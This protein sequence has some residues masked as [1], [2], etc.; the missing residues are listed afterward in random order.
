MTAE[1]A[2][3]ILDPETSR[4]ALR[5]YEEYEDRLEVVNE[6]CRVAC[7]ALC[8]QQDSKGVEIDQFKPV[9][10]DRSRWN[11]CD[12]C[13]SWDTK[14]PID[15]MHGD[16]VIH[17]GAITSFLGYREIY[18]YRDRKVLGDFM[19]CPLCGSPLTEE[20]WADLERRINCGTTD[21]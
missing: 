14:K 3:R 9:K 4:E 20:A 6:A 21:K 17:H 1:E 5:Q 16:I 8:A 19:F 7:A 15:D 11:G 13:I 18:D 10:L 2:I 12:L